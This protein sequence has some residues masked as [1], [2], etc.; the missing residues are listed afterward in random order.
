MIAV[1]N[2]RLQIIGF[3]YLETAMGTNI[4]AQETVDSEYI[5]AIYA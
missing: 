3:T 2:A 5:R 1:F 4:H